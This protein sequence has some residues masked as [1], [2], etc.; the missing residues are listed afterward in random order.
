[1]PSYDAPTLSIDCDYMLQPT[2]AAQ[3]FT[4]IPNGTYPTQSLEIHSRIIRPYQ[5]NQTSASER[6]CRDALATMSS[7]VSA[8]LLPEDINPA[9]A[10]L[11]YESKPSNRSTVPPSS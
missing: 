7:N 3:P 8:S 1:M 4:S 10:P 2:V 5:D 9:P 11:A 6:N